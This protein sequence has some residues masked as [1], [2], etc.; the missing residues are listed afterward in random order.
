MVSLP[1]LTTLY[2][3]MCWSLLNEVREVDLLFRMV[4]DAQRPGK[5]DQKTHVFSPFDDN[6]LKANIIPQHVE[7]PGATAAGA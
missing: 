7:Q 2:Q 6:Y 3:I 5:L 4:T 1:A